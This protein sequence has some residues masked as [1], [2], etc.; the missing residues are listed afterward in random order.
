[1][2]PCGAPIFT[3]FYGVFLHKLLIITMVLNMT[4]TQGATLYISYYGGAGVGMN[5]F[6]DKVATEKSN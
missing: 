1:M 5:K 3:V 6:Q 4:S 2:V